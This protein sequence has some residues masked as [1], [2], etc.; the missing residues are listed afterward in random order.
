[1]GFFVPKC[2]SFSSGSESNSP[3]AEGLKNLL[4]Q[5]S[6]QSAEPKPNIKL[7]KKDL[8][9]LF[10]ALGSRWGGWRA[11]RALQYADK[12]GDGVINHNEMDQLLIYC[13]KHGFL[14][15]KD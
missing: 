10:K 15:D 11:W 4:L 9:E 12:N 6:S 2:A 3:A 8:T 7:T 14:P 13:K 5:A 1:M